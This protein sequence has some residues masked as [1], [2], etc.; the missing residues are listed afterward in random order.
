M[1]TLITIVGLPLGEAEIG[2]MTALVIAAMV[3]VSYFRKLH[4]ELYQQQKQLYD[5]TEFTRTLNAAV[6]RLL[7]IDNAGE[8]DSNRQP[9]K[10]LRAK[11]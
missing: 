4:F 2:F 9:L 3:S 6:D 5:Q 11:A 1:Y 10:G 8:I 7:K